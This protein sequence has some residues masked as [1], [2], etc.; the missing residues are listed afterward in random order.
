MYKEL[1][2]DI[3]LELSNLTGKNNIFLTRRGNISIK[4]SLKYVKSR[5]FKDIFIQDQ[6][7][8]I[9]YP[10]FIKKLKLN[11]VY[12]KTDYGLITNKTDIVLND[13]ILLFN[14]MPGYSFIQNTNIIESKIKNKKNCLIINDVA[15][16]IGHKQAK[17]GDIIIGSFGKDKPINL[18]K[19]GFIATNIKDLNIEEEIF[20]KEELTL[21]LSKLKELPKRI[22]FFNNIHNKIKEEL[23]NINMNVNIIHK[24][25]E[26]I[27][28]IIKFNEEDEKIKKEIIDYCQKNNYEYTQ[29]P[30]YIRIQEN[31]ISIE[32]KRLAKE[33]I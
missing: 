19:G 18:E 14:T 7:G 10:Q 15:G 5:N 13:C 29:C 8:W 21:L 28:V 27:N 12:I 31:G 26:G 25:I 6:G 16:S 11:I 1:I 4:E 33:T 22:E 30:R 3:K 9:T 32:V 24:N 17:W 23:I 2:K 20:S